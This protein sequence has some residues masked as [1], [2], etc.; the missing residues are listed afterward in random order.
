MF[1]LN[2]VTGG[3]MTHAAQAESTKTNW[4]RVVGPE[5][6]VLYSQ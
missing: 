6:T 3:D 1:V 5:V 2:I 4:S